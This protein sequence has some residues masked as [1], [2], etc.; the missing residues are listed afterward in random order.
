MIIIPILISLLISALEYSLELFGFHLYYR[1][2]GFLT[3]QNKFL[4]SQALSENEI[5]KLN[6]MPLKY[7]NELVVITHQNKAP[8]QKFLYQNL[9][10]QYFL[11]ESKLRVLTIGF[12]ALLNIY[13]SLTIS[14]SILI[15]ST[16]FFF[17]IY[18]FSLNTIETSLRE[19]KKDWSG[20]FIVIL[21]VCITLFVL[22][23][24]LQRI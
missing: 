5:D 13:L 20:I 23:Q 24:D 8:L 12:F 4:T 6:E 18:I 3:M 7:R 10:L 14:S 19:Q 2:S 16:T 21:F 15:G 1:K 22:I 9:S 17:L 11:E